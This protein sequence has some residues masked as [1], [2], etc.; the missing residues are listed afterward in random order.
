[1]NT[2]NIM[3]AIVGVIVLMGVVIPLVSSLSDDIH[4]VEYNTGYKYMAVNEIDAAI[5]YTVEDGTVLYNGEPMEGFT[6]D[7]Q[8]TPV[9]LADGFI[10]VYDFSGLNDLVYH[11]SNAAPVLTSFTINPDGTYSYVS[12]GATTSGTYT[13]AI[14]ACPQG[15]YVAVDMD[16]DAQVGINLDDTAYVYARSY[17]SASGNSVFAYAVEGVTGTPALLMSYTTQSVTYDAAPTIN[18]SNDH[19]A[20]IEF[21]T[22][23]TYDG[24]QINAVVVAFVPYAYD[25]INS[26]S[27]M[28]STLVGL[29]PVLLVVG[30]VV[31]IVSGAVLGRKEE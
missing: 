4:A 17:S 16:G 19:S 24:S 29:T 6:P 18:S 1:M 13:D 8:S 31:V 9:I 12:N 23:T 25:T 3:T 14:C 30:L 5:T 22:T 2:K 11:S 15:D 7:D 21:D 10:L 27:E 26:G 20:Q 28:I